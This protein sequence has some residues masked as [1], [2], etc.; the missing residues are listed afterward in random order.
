MSNVLGEEKQVALDDDLELVGLCQKGELSAFEAL[1]EKHQRKMLNIAFRMIGD[2]E[3]ACEV[4][5]DAFLSA[6]KS[7][8]KFRGEAKFSTW[9]CSIVINLSKNRMKQMK[10]RWQREGVSIDDPIETE[11]G[12]I[13]RDPP[14]PEPSVLDQLEKKEIQAKVQACINSL[15]DEY[16]E[17]LILRDIQGFSYDEIQDTLKIPDGTVKSRL[18]RARDTLKD[19]LKDVFGDL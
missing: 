19:R 8:R 3:A 12:Q 4:V 7:I 15:E 2:Y 11:E 5:Q 18:F 6:H 10:T 14:S 16:R 17:V 1:V 9:L 13:R